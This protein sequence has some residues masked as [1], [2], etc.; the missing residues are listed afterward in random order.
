[1]SRARLIFAFASFILLG[2][3]SGVAGVLIPSQMADYQVNKVTI[4]TM[5]FTFSAGYVLSGVGNGSLIRWLGARGQ[6]ALGAAVTGCLA[7]GIGL[8]P[9]FVVLLIANIGLGFGTGILDAGLNAYLTTLP[10]HTTLLN[11]LH[12]FFGVGALIGPVLATALLHAHRPW[13]DVYLLLAVAAVPLLA[14]F[15]T[16]FPSRIAQVPEEEEH[17]AFEGRRA[18]LSAALR[19][20]TV[21]LA[22]TFLCLYVGIEV[23]VGDWSFSL[24]TQQKGAGE[25][26]AGYVVSGY[27]LGLTLGR[28]L[29][30]ASATRA[31]IGVV[32]MMYGC[33][34]GVG[35]ATLLTWLGPG[36]VLVTIGFGLIGF[37]LGP[38]FPTTIAVLPRLAPARL[39]PTA[40]GLLVGASVIGGAVFP[41]LAGSL[42]QGLGL[43]SLLPY[44][45]VLSVLL[46]IVWSTIGRRIRSVAGPAGG[47]LTD[48]GGGL[49]RI[50]TATDSQAH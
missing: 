2:V 5:F 38:V 6:L 10:N 27:W 47:E 36:S 42:A 23:T 11:L 33:L 8:R 30:N 20:P 4:G 34:A 7:Y 14:G 35:V 26:L 1:M 9:S 13:Q 43:G 18:P 17:P 39:V 44:T 48:D 37:F 49:D 12:A 3:T 16:L 50:R 22:A 15:L 25:L 45:L 32:A 41:W 29:L 21:W 46:A 24:L 31:G 40:V 19:H 28:F